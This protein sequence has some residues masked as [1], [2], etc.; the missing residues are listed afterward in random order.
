MNRDSLREAV[1]GTG[2]WAK[3]GVALNE[4]AAP[5]PAE[6][7]IEEAKQRFPIQK[8]TQ[9]NMTV[10]HHTRKQITWNYNLNGAAGRTYAPFLVQSKVPSPN[11]PQDMWIFPGMIMIS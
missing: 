5:A 11:E 6:E 2:A 8:R 1:L 3:S 9:R 10:S 7:V 4:S